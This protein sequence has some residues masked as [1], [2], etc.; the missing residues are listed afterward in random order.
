MPQQTS[1]GVQT[2]CGA[3]GIVTNAVVSTPGQTS[4]HSGIT[5]GD[6]VVASLFQGG[7]A[8]WAEF[9]D[10]TNGSYWSATSSSDVATTVV[11][12]SQSRAGVLP[13]FRRI[14]YSN[15]TVNGDYLGFA[16]VGAQGFKDVVG[17]VTI[18][19]AGPLR[20]SSS[21]TSFT[22]KFKSS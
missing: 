9:H 6:I 11:I 10:L 17:S 1:A 13:T 2:T 5:P 14:V 3:N 15:A 18:M 21:G 22:V 12:G 20:T 16:S 7:S 8:S 19:T 4:Y